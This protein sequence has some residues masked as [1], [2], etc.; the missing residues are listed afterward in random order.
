[1]ECILLIK[2]DSNSEKAKATLLVKNNIDKNGGIRN[3]FDAIDMWIENAKNNR[4]Q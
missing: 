1:M 4:I 2:T 3:I